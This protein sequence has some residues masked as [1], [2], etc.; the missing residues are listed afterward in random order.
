MA[1]TT[2]TRHITGWEEHGLL[3]DLALGES[4]EQLGEK[5]GL[6]VQSAL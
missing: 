2:G 3:R 5:Y 4:P 6:A 1:T